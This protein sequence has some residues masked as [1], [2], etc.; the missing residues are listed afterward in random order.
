VRDTSDGFAP[1]A[2]RPAT[3]QPATKTRT[4]TRTP[5]VQRTPAQ[6]QPAPPSQRV[7]PRA[8]SS[9]GL[10]IAVDEPRAAEVA[11]IFAVG[12]AAHRA[13]DATAARQAYE[14]VLAIAPNDVD[15]INNLGAL[16]ASLREFDRAETTL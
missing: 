1:P 14:Q 6:R 9:N 4:P 8:E 12:V 11:R 13:G 10:R 3:K 2:S 15:A 16:Y 5:V 7:Q